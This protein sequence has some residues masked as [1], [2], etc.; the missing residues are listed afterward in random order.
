MAISALETL[1]SLSGT[2]SHQAGRKI[3]GRGE[4]EIIQLF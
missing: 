4:G 2:Q 1:I 3:V